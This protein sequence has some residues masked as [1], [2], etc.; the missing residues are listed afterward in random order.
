MDPAAAKIAFCTIAQLVNSF[1][2]LFN[3]CSSQRSSML[4][5]DFWFID[6]PGIDIYAYM[7]AI[8]LSA[9]LC[10]RGSVS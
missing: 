3:T 8:V 2:Y 9:Q 5:K 7:L 10:K 4:G 1:Y 6:I